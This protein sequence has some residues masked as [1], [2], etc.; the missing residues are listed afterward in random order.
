LTR[1]VTPARVL[2]LAHPRTG[3]SFGAMIAS[4][5]FYFARA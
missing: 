2:V 4:G 3:R 5:I 1:A